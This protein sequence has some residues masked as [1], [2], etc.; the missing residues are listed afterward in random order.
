M[1][2]KCK[3]SLAGQWCP[4]R[5]TCLHWLDQVLGDDLR[6]PQTEITAAGCAGYKKM[7]MGRF[8]HEHEKRVERWRAAD[9]SSGR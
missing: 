5:F 4:V 6:E 2:V 9:G 3:G 1:A 7:T 8:K